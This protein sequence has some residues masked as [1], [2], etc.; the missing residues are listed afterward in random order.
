VKIWSANRSAVNQP[1]ADGSPQAIFQAAN[2]VP[3]DVDGDTAGSSPNSFAQTYRSSVPLALGLTERLREC[4]ELFTRALAIFQAVAR[5]HGGPLARN[6]NLRILRARLLALALLPTLAFALDPNSLKP[7]GYVSDFA[8]AIDADSRAKLE[9]YCGQ[10]ERA[11]GVQIALVTVKSLEGAQIED[12]ANSL[13]R[14]WGVGKKGK[15]EGLMLLLSI[16]DHKDR[17]EVG[18]GLEP[19]LPDGFVGEVLF[20]ARPYLAKGQY[21]QALLAAADTMGSRIAAQKGVALDTSV[22]P[23]RTQ[24]TPQD[25]GIPWWVV[26]IGILVLFF[27]LRSGGGGFLAGMILSNLMGGG[28]RRGGGGWGGGGFGGGDGGFGGF[29]GG[30]SGGGGAS[31]DW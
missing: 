27:I 20:Q 23:P 30:D 28:G 4:G 15:D 18:Y 3:P 19:I 13:F 12:F 8:N 22:R 16:D 11:T 17:I 2:P 29:G 9:D 1:D 31:G 26:V 5:S 6:S 24:E 7:Q 25:N 10:V 21:G 14:K